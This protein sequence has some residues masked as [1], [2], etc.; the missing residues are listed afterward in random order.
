MACTFAFVGT[1]ASLRAPSA[2][3]SNRSTRVVTRA[4][5]SSA[6]T[7]VVTPA[8]VG[9]RSGSAS[10][11]GTVRKQNEDRFASYV[12]LPRCFSASRAVPRNA[13]LAPGTPASSARDDTV[14]T[15]DLR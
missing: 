12:R 5:A 14:T 1:P 10:V 7:C 11:K 3:R 6:A 13:T 9:Q 15:T 8:T 2:T 4:D